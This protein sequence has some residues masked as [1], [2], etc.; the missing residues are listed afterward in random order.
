MRQK[1][2]SAA[3]LVLIGIFAVAWIIGGVFGVSSL[4]SAAP[5]TIMIDFHDS[6]YY[7][8]E[9]PYENLNDAIA[10]AADGDTVKLNLEDHVVQNQSIKITQ[11][12]TLSGT[13]TTAVLEDEDGIV[14]E[15]NVTFSGLT[16]RSGHL[17]P[18]ISAVTVRPGGKLT[19]SGGLFS[20]AAITGLAVD[21]G[22]LASRN[23]MIRSTILTRCSI[24]RVAL[25]I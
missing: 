16:F 4:A 2:C 25:A 9:V 11:D 22:A 1:R 19:V 10:T 17:I 8:G 12:I 20:I 6:A 21:K 18:T 24:S 7:I 15:G 5:Q 23:S 13:L 14:I 3:K